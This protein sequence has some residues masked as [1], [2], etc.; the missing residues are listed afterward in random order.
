MPSFLDDKD[1]S[2]QE[3][4]DNVLWRLGLEPHCLPTN[5]D[6]CGYPFLVEHAC[7]CKISGLVNLHHNLLADEW[8]DLC[9]KF[10]TPKAVFEETRIYTENQLKWGRGKAIQRRSY[11]AVDARAHLQ[12]RRSSI[13]GTGRRTRTHKQDSG[14]R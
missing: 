4:R 2:A 10:L 13:R 5:C 11:G 14:R 12:R 6:G 7:C 8:G 1:L 3:F 9:V